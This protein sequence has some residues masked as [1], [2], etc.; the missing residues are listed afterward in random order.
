MHRLQS[1][2]LATGPP[3]SPASPN[4]RAPTTDAALA[5]LLQQLS[6][7]QAADAL[8]QASN[9]FEAGSGPGSAGGEAHEGAASSGESVRQLQELVAAAL[10]RASASHG[11]GAE[12]AAG[13]ALSDGLSWI[14][15]PTESAQGAAARA[16]TVAAAA[17][18]LSPAAAAIAA[19]GPMPRL[20]PRPSLNMVLEFSS[21]PK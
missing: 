18:A 15:D 6:Q 12:A 9:G 19:A 21:I 16:D 2:V 8:A 3:L 1:L 11:A 13:L 17:V 20:P 10:G 14:Y 4:H 7:L 5:R